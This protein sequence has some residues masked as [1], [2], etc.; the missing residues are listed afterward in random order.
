V[1]AKARKAITTTKNAK[2]ASKK[3][4]KTSKST[5]IVI[6][7]V[8]STFLG[9]LSIEDKVEVKE[10][11]DIRGVVLVTTRRGKKVKLLVRLQI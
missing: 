1:A 2:K 11:K 9:N 3:A 5:Q 10:V 4:L 8:R 6:L 7:K